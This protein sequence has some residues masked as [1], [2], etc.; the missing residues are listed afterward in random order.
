MFT[1]IIKAIGE[2][3]E[4]QERDGDLRIRVVTNNLDL[5]DVMRGDSISTNGVCLTAVSLPGDGFCADVSQ[6]TIN[7]TTIGQWQIGEKVNL[8]KA[9]TFSDRL[10]GHIVSGHVDGV[11]TIVGRY[12]DARSERFSVQVP[13]SLEKY[14]AGKGSITVDGTSLTVNRINDSEPGKNAEFD[15]NIVP[16]TLSNTIMADYQKGMR[17]NLEVD[18][19]ARYLE[20]L[21]KVDES[22]I[23]GKLI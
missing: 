8:E 22:L 15:I 14:I 9:L 17:V 5:G 11:G 16:H 20:R 4:S 23:P 1:G 18:L 12:S 3:I 21:L 7:H 19:M 6:E 10:G 2:V 13:S